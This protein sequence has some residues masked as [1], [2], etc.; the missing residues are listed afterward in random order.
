MFA[1]REQIKTHTKKLLQRWK[2]KTGLTDE[3][4]A[5]RT[6]I[7]K[8]QV[9]SHRD[10]CGALPNAVD[11]IEYEGCY[12]EEFWNEYQSISGL[13]GSYRAVAL[14]GCLVHITA[15][16]AQRAADFLQ[17]ANGALADVKIDHVER[18]WLPEIAVAL[19][20]HCFQF[21]VTLR[22]QN[23]AGVL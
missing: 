18:R 13:T 15:L 8:R 10:P 4:I 9:T 23:E 20:H 3:E 17:R 12:G 16:Q 21:A 6:G 22:G 5:A 7:G 1:T 14:S 19:G 2:D 11:M